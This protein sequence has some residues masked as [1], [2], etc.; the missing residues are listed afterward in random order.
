LITIGKNLFI[1]CKISFCGV[2]L[3]F[4]LERNQFIKTGPGKLFAINNSSIT[5]GFD[6]GIE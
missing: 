6:F 1:K 3:V 2:N 4:Y 5:P